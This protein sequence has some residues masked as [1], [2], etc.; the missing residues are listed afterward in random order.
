MM[1]D[2][3]NLGVK[4]APRGDSNGFLLISEECEDHLRERVGFVTHV[5]PPN[6]VIQVE[7]CTS[8]HGNRVRKQIETNEEGSLKY[9]LFVDGFK[10]GEF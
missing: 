4:A 6:G 1:K 8:C 5:N 9:G 10:F 7:R 3:F 2:P